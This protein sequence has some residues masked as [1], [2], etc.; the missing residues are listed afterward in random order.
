[1]TQEWIIKTLLDLGF[2]QQEAEVY[3]LLRHG[4]KKATDI[5]NE[6]KIYKRKVYRILKKLKETRIIQA[7]ATLPS[8]FQAISLDNFLDLLIENYLRDASCLEEEKPKIFANWKSIIEKAE[9]DN[10][11]EN[12]Q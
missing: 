9:F 8:Q 7:K 11:G 4:P 6:L 2:S 3:L 10:T 5:S 1:M 12:D